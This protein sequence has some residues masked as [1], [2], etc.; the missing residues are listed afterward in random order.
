MP[1]K[2]ESA[3]M[4]PAC[5]CGTR[6][7]VVHLAVANTVHGAPVNVHLDVDRV[8]HVNYQPTLHTMVA[9]GQQCHVQTDC[10]G[11]PSVPLA[12]HLALASS[13]ANVM[14]QLAAARAELARSAANMVAEM[15]D[16]EHSH[17][18]TRANSEPRLHEH[19]EKVSLSS[20][21]PDGDHC[22][23]TRHAHGMYPPINGFLAKG[24]EYYEWNL[25]V[26][27]YYEWN[28]VVCINVHVPIRLCHMPQHARVTCFDRCTLCSVVCA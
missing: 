28:L 9:L 10:V 26:C 14:A 27:T 17:A 22:R 19:A 25:V 1:H 3:F 12:E 24:R 11:R 4:A 7:N 20:A 18:C 21:V 13:Y 16:G 23:V 5:M 15:P 6:P 8:T 2:T